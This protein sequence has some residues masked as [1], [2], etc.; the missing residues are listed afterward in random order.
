MK[1]EMLVGSGN[2]EWLKKAYLQ[3]ANEVYRQKNYC[4]ALQWE[5]MGLAEDEEI[6]VE[7][8]IERYLGRMVGKKLIE[9]NLRILINTCMKRYCDK[10]RDEGKFT[11]DLNL[12]FATYCL[13]MLHFK[14]DSLDFQTVFNILKSKSLKEV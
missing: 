13:A 9:E 11:L 8:L 6:V 10:V 12:I 4:K 2:S 7:S 1:L 14:I 5:M 3:K